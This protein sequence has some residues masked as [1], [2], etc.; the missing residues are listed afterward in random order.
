LSIETEVKI[1]IEDL[2]R[3]C[4]QLNALKPAVISLRHFENNRLLDFSDQRLGSAS[5]LFRLRS[6]G[7]ECLLTYKGP[8]LPDGVF[9]IRE[10]LEVTVNRGAALLQMLERIGMQT[11]F[12]Y[13]KYRREFL[14]DDVH[15]TVDETPIGNYAE[16]EGTQ[17]AIRG[18]ARR[19]NIPESKF[20]R[21]S[22]YSL[23]V[24]YCK[25]RGETP[26]FMVF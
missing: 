4:D 20:L 6:V 15:I 22:Y 12:Q 8:P 23:Y 25:Q 5:C 3:F 26:G 7:E 24:D 10:E 11:S 14:L 21:Q 18:L 1:K 2:P 13:Q 17:D 16:L 9:K 19:M